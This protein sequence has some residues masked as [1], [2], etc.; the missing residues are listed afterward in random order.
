V[1]FY[2][3]DF[4]T[5]GRK[6]CDAPMCDLHAHTVGDDIHVCLDH[7]EAW[8]QEGPGRQQTMFNLQRVK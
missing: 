7:K 2:L 6:P 1:A 5:G 3:C 4:P 8:Y